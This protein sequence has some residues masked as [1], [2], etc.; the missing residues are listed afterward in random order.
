[1][2][3]PTRIQQMVTNLALNARD[4]MPQ[5]GA[6]RIGLGRVE[7]KPGTPPPLPEME[8]GSWIQLTVSDTGT[9]IP[10]DVLPHIFEPF[11]T[12]KEPGIGTGLGL[13]QVYGIVGQHEG[14]IDVETQVG[15]GTTFAIYLPALLDAPAGPPVPELSAMPQGHRQTVLVVED[16]MSVRKALVESLETLN[17]QVLEAASGQDAL[18]I[19]DQ[20]EVALV[21]SD[22]VMPR[23]G[24]IA[25]FHAMKQKGLMMPMVLLT[26]HPME[27]ALEGLQA[28]GLSA[29]LPKPPELERLAKVVARALMMD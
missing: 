23:M 9:G 1:M 19:L 18:E 28:E 10:P 24:G 2:A 13:A 4:A 14:R 25:L 3:D 11:F 7:V 20:H 21:L 5:G 15:D 12:T 29:W 6:L 27:K 22:V 17:Y 16:E 26:G 8:A